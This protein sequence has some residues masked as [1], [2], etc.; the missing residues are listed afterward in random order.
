MQFGPREE[1][2]VTKEDK[3]LG[4]PRNL[5][6]PPPGVKIKKNLNHYLTNHNSSEK[7]ILNLNIV[8][9]FSVV[10]LGL[11]CDDDSIKIYE[12]DRSG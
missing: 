10:I 2:P 6:G 9:G 1:C 7:K 4:P 5:E 11:Y 3:A 8:Y 12:N